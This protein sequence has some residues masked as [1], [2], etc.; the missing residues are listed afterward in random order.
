M[1]YK[2]GLWSAVRLM[3]H[4]TDD[5]FTDFRAWLISQ[6]KEAYFAALKE[7]DTLADLDP[8]DGYWFESF[9]RRDSIHS[10]LCANPWAC[11][12]QHGLRKGDTA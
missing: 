6:G 5:G 4:A 7:P 11:H 8:G 12:Y 3:G 2:Y 9:Q 1:A 10:Q